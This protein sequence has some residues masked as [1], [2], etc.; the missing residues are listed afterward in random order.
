MNS[1]TGTQPHR[2]LNCLV[3]V[4]GIINIMSSKK[5]VDYKLQ[6]ILDH[7]QRLREQLDL[8]RV[9]VSQ[10]S[11]MLIKYVQ[12]TKD[13]LVPSVWGPAGPADPFVTKGGISC[14][15]CLIS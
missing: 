3:Y 13:Y 12:S 5:N 6:R 11:S 8:P 9:R 1:K 2:S 14:G 10:A 7:N 4:P 15:G